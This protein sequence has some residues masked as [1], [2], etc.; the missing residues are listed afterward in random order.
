MCFIVRFLTRPQIAS[1]YKESSGEWL[2]FR[3]RIANVLYCPVSE[4]PHIHELRLRQPLFHREMKPLRQSN[5][6]QR[7]FREWL[8]PRTAVVLSM[9][10]GKQKRR[11]VVSHIRMLKSD[12]SWMGMRPLIMGT[13]HSTYTAWMSQTRRFWSHLTE[14]PPE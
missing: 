1:S 14:S 5:G 10:A 7:R 11:A 13:P 2:S 4:E 12:E 9:G 3:G 8:F 6:R